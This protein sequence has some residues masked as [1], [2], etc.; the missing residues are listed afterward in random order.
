MN[1]CCFSLPPLFDFSLFKSALLFL[2]IQSFKW[3]FPK[4]NHSLVSCSI[5]H[6]CMIFA[7]VENLINEKEILATKAFQFCCHQLNSK[8]KHTMLHSSQ[9]SS[10]FQKRENTQFYQSKPNA[11]KINALLHKDLFWIFSSS[12]GYDWWKILTKIC[13][14]MASIERFMADI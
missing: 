7:A 12:F 2:S 9:Y 13:A 8:H 5:V 11:C 6:S 10:I 3:Y 1:F 14:W 4:R